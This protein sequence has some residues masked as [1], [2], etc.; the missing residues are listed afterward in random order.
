LSCISCHNQHGSDS[1]KLFRFPADVAYDI[2]VNCHK[3]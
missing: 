2:C 3:K 1:K